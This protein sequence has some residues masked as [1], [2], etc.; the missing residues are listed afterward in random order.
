LH[1]RLERAFARRAAGAE[2]HGEER[3]LECAEL[4]PG[5][6]KLAA[7]FGG[8]GREKLEADRPAGE[9][10]HRRPSMNGL[11]AAYTAWFT[12]ASKPASRAMR[13]TA[14][15]SHGASSR[16]PA[17]RSC[18][19]EAFISCGIVSRYFIRSSTKLSASGTPRARASAQVSRNAL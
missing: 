9:P 7:A 18:A 19:I 1:H 6:A 11:S 17:S 5:V 4:L 2:G 16:P 15:H 13:T 14:P 10:A 8:L 12:G 3:G